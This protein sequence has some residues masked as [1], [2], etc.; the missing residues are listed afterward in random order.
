MG[1]AEI[2]DL[3]FQYEMTDA[4]P[5][6]VL[7]G[8]NLELKKGEFTAVAVSQLLQSISMQYCF[9]QEEQSILTELTQK[10][11]TKFLI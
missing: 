3:E 8:I 2:K 9:R 5:V 10:T 7:R 4:E 1:K 6:K 11:K